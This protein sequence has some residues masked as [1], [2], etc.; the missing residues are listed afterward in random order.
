MTLFYL[1]S[2]F[3]STGFSN[4]FISR[5][6]PSHIHFDKHKHIT[7]ISLLSKGILSIINP[8]Q[9]SLLISPQKS[10]KKE[11]SHLLTELVID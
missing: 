1:K 4:Q 3:E 2:F 11:L 9:L 7:A 8:N 5:V 10:Q 6:F